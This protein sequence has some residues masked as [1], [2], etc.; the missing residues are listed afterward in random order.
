M[1]DLR[2]GFDSLMQCLDAPM[3]IVTTA[4]GDERAGCLVG[5]H[6]QSS[7]DPQRYCVWLSKANHTYRLAL[8]STHLGI[9]FLSRVD[10]DLAEVFGALTGDEVDKFALVD[11][12]AGPEGIPLLTR[13]PNRLV[14]HRIALLDEGG[15]HVCVTTEPVAAEFGDRFVPLR[16]SDVAG[17][18][19][20]HE[21]AERPEPRRGLEDPTTLARHP[22]GDMRP[23]S[24]ITTNL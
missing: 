9:H 23:N 7:I 4:V 5:F 17:L 21:A 2:P 6:A 18:V 3:A 15:D 10:R 8:R 12:A 20:G 24:D 13:C 14:V 22:K 16:L 19:P 11:V 1:A